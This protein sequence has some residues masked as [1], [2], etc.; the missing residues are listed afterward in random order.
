MSELQ[1]KFQV[2]ELNPNH[3]PYYN[4]KTINDPNLNRNSKTTPTLTGTRFGVPTLHEC[5]SDG[6]I[7]LNPTGN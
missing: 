5:T 2:L 1:N 4:S 6:A 3:N 7:C